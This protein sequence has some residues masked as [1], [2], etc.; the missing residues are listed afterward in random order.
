MSLLD[1]CL[2]GR[3]D[4]HA[5]TGNATAEDHFAVRA[6]VTRQAEKFRNAR[7]Y[8][9]FYTVQLSNGF[10]LLIESASDDS[11]LPPNRCAEALFGVPIRGAALVIQHDGAMFSSLSLAS[12]EDCW[13]TEAAAAVRSTV[14]NGTRS[15][16]LQLPH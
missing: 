6:G 9:G 11:G 15:L 1:F 10:F 2:N 5:C 8:D 12:I 3:I 13:Q 14:E 16:H 7:A 4:R